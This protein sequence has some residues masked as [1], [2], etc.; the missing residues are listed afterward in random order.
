MTKAD[1]VDKV[2]EQVGGFSKKEAADLVE[3][4]AFHPHNSRLAAAAKAMLDRA[5]A[6]EKKKAANSPAAASDAK[7]AD[8]S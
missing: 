4:L 6:G 5:R 2:C 1:I 8:P 7:T 3:P